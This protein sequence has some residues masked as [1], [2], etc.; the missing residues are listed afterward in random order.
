ML[1][2]RGRRSNPWRVLLFLIL[3]GA[4]L[5]V[6]QVVVPATHPLFIPTAEP[7]RSPESFINEAIADFEAGRLPQAINA[8][9]QAVSVDPDNASIYVALARAQLYSGQYEEALESADKAIILNNDNPMAH[10]FKAWALDSLGD[11]TQ[12]EAAVTRAIELDANNAVAHAV[13]AIIL[14]N[15]AISGQG[16]LGL[17]DRAAEASRLALNLDNSLM[18]T[19]RA[20]GFVL[21]HTG[22]YQESI[23]EYQAAVAI[24]D[25]IADLHLALGYNYRAIQ[26]YVKAVESFHQATSLK[27]NDPIPPLEISRTYYSIGDFAQ[28]LQYAEQAVKTDPNNPRWRA[29]LGLMYYKNAMA[30]NELSYLQDAIAELSI[31]IQGGETEDGHIIEGMPLNYGTVAEYYAIYGLALARSNRCSEA[32]P[33]FQVILSGVPNDEVNVYNAEF[34]LE[35]CRENAGESL[36]DDIS[37]EDTSLAP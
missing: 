18:E 3:I 12:A 16:D 13:H 23:Q 34:G 32:I 2:K 19:R 10:T 17:I 1:R 27:P 29:N 30:M 4:A 6:N 5:Y 11:Q 36:E 21:W 7:T 35:L 8:Y 25:R 33:I 15:R 22:N 14:T 20:R 9:K 37:E 24:N 31:A 28:A 26:D